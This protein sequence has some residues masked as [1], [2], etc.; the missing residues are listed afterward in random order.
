LEHCTALLDRLLFHE[1]Q[2]LRSIPKFPMPQ[3]E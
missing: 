2:Q 1:T 3:N